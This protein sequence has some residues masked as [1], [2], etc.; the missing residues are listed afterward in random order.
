MAW[1]DEAVLA[2]IRRRY[3]NPRE[4]RVELEIGR[5]ERDLV[6]ASGRSGRRHDVTFFVFNGH[7]LALIQKPHYEPGVWRPPGGGLRPDEDFVAGV[8]REALEELGVEIALEY[9]LVD[10]DAVFTHEGERIAWRTHVVSARTEAEELA[11]FDT[12][13]ISAAR[14]GTAEELAGPIRDRLLATG[15]A[16][17]KYRVRLHEAALA[18][19]ASPLPPA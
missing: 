19:L 15:R 16:L 2:E 12:H 5:A 11:P 8:L 3:G 9:Y 10:A 13:E 1:V 17:W 6:V 18:E 7:R 4:L 14:W